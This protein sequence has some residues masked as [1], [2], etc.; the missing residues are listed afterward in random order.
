MVHGASYVLSVA[1]SV[2]APPPDLLRHVFLA[3]RLPLWE[4]TLCNP[5]LTT[6]GSSLCLVCFVFGASLFCKKQKRG[7]ALERAG[8]S[9]IKCTGHN[10]P[11]GLKRPKNPRDVGEAGPVVLVRKGRS[12]PTPFHCTMDTHFLAPGKDKKV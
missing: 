10:D 8:I 12:C 3:S 9:G 4:P 11:L 2:C 5:W 6:V 1:M 7:C